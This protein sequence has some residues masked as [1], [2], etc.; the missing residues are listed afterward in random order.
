MTGRAKQPFPGFIEFTSAA[1]VRSFGVGLKDV[2]GVDQNGKGQPP[3]WLHPFVAPA[4]GKELSGQDGE[5]MEDAWFKDLFHLGVSS[6]KDCVGIQCVKNRFTRR[7]LI[8]SSLP[9]N[10][11]PPRTRDTFAARS[12][13]ELF[14]PRTVG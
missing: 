2:H 9:A 13:Q 12:V 8:L 1:V 10:L 14:T 11:S 3:K 5:I 7:C 4:S 6:M